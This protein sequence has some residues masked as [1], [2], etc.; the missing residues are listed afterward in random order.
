MEID[1]FDSLQEEVAVSYVPRSREFSL[2]TKKAVTIS[3][4]GDFGGPLKYPGTRLRIAKDR[5]AVLNGKICALFV[6][7]HDDHNHFIQARHHK[8][9][10]DFYAADIKTKEWWLITSIDICFCYKTSDFKEEDRSGPDRRLDFFELVGHYIIVANNNMRDELDLIS[11]FTVIDLWTSESRQIIRSIN[12]EHITY[13]GVAKLE[14]IGL[15]GNTIFVL[16]RRHETLYKLPLG[17]APLFDT[18]VYSQ[19]GPNACCYQIEGDRLY[20]YKANKTPPSL[21]L[22]SIS[23]MM[24]IKTLSILPIKNDNPAKSQVVRIRS[25]TS[26]LVLLAHYLDYFELNEGV[27]KR[28]Y[29]CLI[30]GKLNTIHHSICIVN[31]ISNGSGLLHP[32]YLSKQVWLGG[33]RTNYPGRVRFPFV[34]DRRNHY[35]S[36]GMDMEDVGGGVTIPVL[37]VVAHKRLLVLEAPT[38]GT[39]L[40][41]GTSVE[42]SDIGFAKEGLVIS[43]LKDQEYAPG[44]WSVILFH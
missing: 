32:L 28:A 40:W 20:C 22:I 37:V 36:F 34:L 33:F 41:Y 17:D 1:P 38:F 25:T 13:N 23:T 12:Y 27:Y 21:E 11:E 7:I 5:L 15:I 42:V 2:N 30:D 4:A 19:V 35:R 18:V 16:D 24:P 26:G 9:M 29:L 6:T 3:D 43:E 31:Y 44:E 14:G 39:G 10:C 8:H